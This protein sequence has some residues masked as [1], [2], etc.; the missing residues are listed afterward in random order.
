MQK[1][2]RLYDMNYVI[3]EEAGLN[4]IGLN[5]NS[6]SRP[7]GHKTWMYSVIQRVFSVNLPRT[8]QIA[9][10]AGMTMMWDNNVCGVL[11]FE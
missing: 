5:L 3:P 2:M 8:F 10:Y 7:K 4:S 11:L 1:D 9:A 6:Q